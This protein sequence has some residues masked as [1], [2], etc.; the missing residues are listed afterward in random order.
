MSEQQER[1]LIEAHRVVTAL[2]MAGFP[3]AVVAGGYLRDTVLGIAPK[4]MD[5]FIPHCAQ[6]DNAIL[7]RNLAGAL[8]EPVTV[9]HNISAYANLEVCRIFECHNA[10]RP[11]PV[12]VIEMAPGID[13]AERAKGHDFGLCQ[14]WMGLD[15]RLRGTDQAWKDNRELTFTLTHAETFKEWERSQRRWVRLAPKLQPL[16]FK[17]VDTTEWSHDKVRQELGL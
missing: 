3:G 16:G 15:G 2:Y 11:V 17:M 1:A 10:L 7:C 8:G 12:Q 6:R 5:V 4:D 9:Q 14:F 13:P